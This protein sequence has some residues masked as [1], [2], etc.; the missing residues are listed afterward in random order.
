M[1]IVSN[2]YNK[3][4]DGIQYLREVAEST[5]NFI[6]T[7]TTIIT[8]TYNFL[9]PIFSFLPWEVI[10]VLVVTILLLSWVNGLFPTTPKLN[11]TLIVIGICLAWGYSDSIS[12]PDGN[13]A[14]GRIFRVILY[15]LLP[16][17]FL[18]LCGY[19]WKFGWKKYQKSLRTR[20]AEWEDFLGKYNQMSHRLQSEL[21]S[22][23]AGD[24]SKVTDLNTS[25]LEMETFLQN[26]RLKKVP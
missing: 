20:P 13:V 15:L 5:Q 22:V 7:T 17:H 1:T 24:D 21:H 6:D 3:L 23:L 9:E 12:S 18:S 16:V 26:Q 19:A 4:L 10:L 14:Y 8:R 25:L 2:A 11:Y